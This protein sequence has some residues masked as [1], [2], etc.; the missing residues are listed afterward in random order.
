MEEGKMSKFSKLSNCLV[1]KYS[2]S[3]SDANKFVKE[4]FNTIKDHL[5]MDK[6]VK[7]KGLGTFKIVEM[8]ARESI[9]VNTRERIVIEAKN[10]IS[11]TPENAVRDRINSPF[12][13][14]ETIEIEDDVDFDEINKRYEVEMPVEEQ[15]S[16]LEPALEKESQPMTETE[17]KN[18]L[19]VEEEPVEEPKTMTEPKTEH[20]TEEEE[21]PKKR[22]YITIIVVVVALLI[23][24]GIGYYI[25]KGTTKG[26]FTT[27]E[28]PTEETITDEVS[29]EEV[30]G[31]EIVKDMAGEPQQAPQEDYNSDARIRTGAYDIV[32]TETT[33]IVREGQTLKGISRAYLGD[34]MECYV[35]V[36]NGGRKEVNVGDELK[37]PKLKYK[38]N[39]KKYLKR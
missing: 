26:N 1:E 35:E 17:P 9:D 10:K 31:E 2:M 12:A 27:D 30:T 19:E 38:E 14:F 3:Q 25:G 23:A 15:A 6:M 39:V 36:Y 28:A 24:F 34:G 7:V 32:G 5:E 13:Q 4:M 21:L 8:S 29:T 37:I 22:N 33:V 11:F 20:E 16:E 18:K